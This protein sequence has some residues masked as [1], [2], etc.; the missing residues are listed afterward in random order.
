MWTHFLTNNHNYDAQTPR[1][2][3]LWNTLWIVC[4]NN[5]SCPQR[6]HFIIQI[7][8]LWTR[9]S[10][11]VWLY[12]PDG[13]CDL[14]PIYKDLP[15]LRDQLYPYHLFLQPMYFLRHEG[16]QFHRLCRVSVQW[17]LI[18]W[19]DLLWAASSCVLQQTILHWHICIT[20]QNT[21]MRL[22]R[23]CSVKRDKLLLVN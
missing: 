17:R 20:W 10:H 4:T 22:I 2:L 11:L 3:G 5:I 6:L 8:L 13:P 12:L 7:Y 21:S 16:L 23:V 1:I 18:R 9:Y 14:H 19:V 15:S